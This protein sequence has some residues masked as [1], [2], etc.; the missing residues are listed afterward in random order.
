[1][2][3]SVVIPSKSRPKQSR[4]LMAAIQSIKHAWSEAEIIVA[5]DKVEV[6]EFAGVHF[7]EVEGNQAKAMNVG[8]GAATGDY[9]AFLEDDDC[10]TTWRVTEALAVMD[11]ADFTSSNQLEFD[12]SGEILR[13]NDFPTPSGWFMKRKVWEAVGPFN[14]EFRFHLDNEWLGRLNRTDFRRVHL[15]EA[16]APIDP[17]QAELYRP[18]LAMVAKAG[19]HSSLRRTSRERPLIERLVH[20][21]SN[22]ARISTT[23]AWAEQSMRE[24]HQLVKQFGLM[25]R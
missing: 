12:D 6:G 15:V 13:V 19:M 22:M 24:T 23:P 21:Q 2:S 7:I 3:V 9:L 20:P 11:D 4:F 16:T 5:T 10:W 14:D 17:R 25:P 1:M 8:A 18:W